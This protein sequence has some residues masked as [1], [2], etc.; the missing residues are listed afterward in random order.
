MYRSH[1]DERR[2]HQVT[3]VKLRTDGLQD[4]SRGA[5]ES[6]WDMFPVQDISFLIH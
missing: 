6:N 4:G 5:V 3:A 2:S 1:T